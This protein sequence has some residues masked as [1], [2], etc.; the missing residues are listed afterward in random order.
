MQSLQPSALTRRGQAWGAPSRGRGMLGVPGEL[1]ESRQ[2]GHAAGRPS[3]AEGAPEEPGGGC[4]GRA[5]RAGERGCPCR[6]R[7]PT[8]RGTVMATRCEA[9]CWVEKAG[10][11]AKG[12]NKH[13]CPD[14]WMDRQNVVHPDSRVFSHEEERSTDT[15]CRWDEPRA[16]VLGARSWPRET[17]QHHETTPRVTPLIGKSQGPLHGDRR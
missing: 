2:G 7:V 14:W 8:A 12:G 9:T 10:E 3:K 15:G 1:L 11:G 4:P 5:E 6:L 16:T 13:V 17:A